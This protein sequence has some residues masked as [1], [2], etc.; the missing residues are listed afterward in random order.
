MTSISFHCLLGFSHAGRGIAAG[1]GND[2]LDRP[3]QPAAFGIFDVSP[4]FCATAHLFPYRT[5]RTGQSQRHTD[6]D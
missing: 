3:A 2:Q 6:A 1:I 5:Q 4:E